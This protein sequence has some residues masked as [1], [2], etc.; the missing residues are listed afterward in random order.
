MAKNKKTLWA[1]MGAHQFHLPEGTPQ[2]QVLDGIIT[3]VYPALD[4]I[5]KRESECLTFLEGSEAKVLEKT[6]CSILLMDPWGTQFRLVDA[7]A[8]QLTGRDARGVQ[9]RGDT[10]E[11]WGMSDVTFYTDQDCNF[12]GIG[13]FYEAVLGA[14]C[15]VHS[16]S[17]IVSVGPNQSL[18]FQR[19]PDPLQQVTHVDLKETDEGTSNWGPHVS[20][21]VA[22]LKATYERA[23]K[24]QLTYVNPRFKRRAYNLE[25]ALDQCMFRCIDIIDPEN[26]AAGPIL[27][28]EHEIRS[29][30]N[31][32][33]SKYKSCPFEEIPIQCK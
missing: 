31:V 6:S 22:D 10:S 1:N 21:Y 26:Q 4:G 8:S 33:G 11:A 13:R 32:D 29:V 3:L 30:T 15:V 2:A 27:Q 7:S 5:R 24:F 23:A 17:C 14:Q 9:A 12:P 18:T 25:E 19:H 16:N 28:L 20:M